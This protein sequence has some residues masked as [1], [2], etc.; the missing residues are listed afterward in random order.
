MYINCVQFII[1]ILLLYVQERALY[2]KYDMIDL[3]RCNYLSHFIICLFDTPSLVML[4]LYVGIYQSITIYRLRPT[5]FS[6][7]TAKTT[8]YVFPE[9]K[10]QCP[11]PNFQIHV[12]VS[13]LYSPNISPPTLLQQSR[14]TDR[15][16]I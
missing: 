14:W 13:D 11:V 7:Y 5:Q 6:T 2:E 9:T 15:G 12:S 3:V 1:P 16:N 4:M 8:I 10:L